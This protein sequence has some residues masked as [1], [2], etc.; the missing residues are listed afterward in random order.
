MTFKFNWKTV[1][2]LL[3][4]C[5]LVLCAMDYLCWPAKAEDSSAGTIFTYGPNYNYSENVLPNNSY[6]HQGENIS[7]GDYYDLSGVYGFSGVLGWWKDQWA[8]GTTYPDKTFDLNVMHLRSIYIDPE[9]WP[10]GKYYQFDGAMYGDNST[11]GSYFGNGNCYVFY[12]T[13]PAENW[14][15]TIT[16][17]TKTGEIEVNVGGN[18]THVQV[19]Y[20]EQVIETQTPV[21]TATIEGQH[22][23]VVGPQETQAM[24]TAA[25]VVDRNG[26]PVNNVPEGMQQVTAKAPV[27]AGIVIAG[28]VGGILLVK[29]RR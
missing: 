14:T 1:I 11:S 5:I 24:P 18:I 7:Q 28:L 20:T 27:S 15:P 22:T 26:Y 6:V 21:P 9:K 25:N 16:N 3:V 2:P 29:R 13:K 10:V 17:V 19:T 4:I 8:P 23:I 12:V